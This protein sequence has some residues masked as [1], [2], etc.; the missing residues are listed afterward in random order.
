MSESSGSEVDELI[1]TGEGYKLEFKE[2]LSSSIGKEICAFANSSGGKIIIGVT[3]E[4]KKV[5][6]ELSNDDSSRIQNI[7]RNMEPSLAVSVDQVGSVVVVK[8]EDGDRKPYSVSGNF[9]LRIGS[10][11][12]KLSRD[13][14]RKFFQRE[15]AVKFDEQTDNDFQLETDFNEDAFETFLTRADIDPVIP[16]QELLQNL[17]FMADS[18]MKNAGVLFFCEDVTR[19]FRNATITCVLYQGNS[20]S[21][22]LDKKEFTADLLSNFENTFSYITEKLSTEYV[23]REERD[24][25]LELPEEALREAILNAIAHRDYFS[26]AHIQI[27]IFK[28]SLEIVNPASY[29]KHID[30][31]DLLNGS[32]PKNLYLFSMMQ[33]AQ[34]VE[35]IGSG[36]TRIKDSMK[37]YQLEQP[38]ISYNGTWFKITFQRPHLETNSYQDRVL[39]NNVTPTVTANVTLNDTQ[40]Q[41]LSA[42][43]ENP[44]TT[45]DKLAEKTGKSRRTIIRNM[46]KLQNNNIVKRIGPDKTGHWK[47]TK[48]NE[49]NENN[50][51]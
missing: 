16:A 38:E 41:I 4:N 49:T 32:H 24:E 20:K 3:D 5:G 30:A 7:A 18:E 6:Y 11:S 46:N 29:P 22:V 26:S 42:I 35:K 44:Q 19:F 39:D 27:N 28:Q 9:Y 51:E 34:L 33:R 47:I 40:K 50:N 48:N 36:I 13:E 31:D 14:I 45:H 8:V 23:I 21:K 37:Q 1:Q 12:Q 10:N 17:G 43:T 2:Q 15:G 25:Y